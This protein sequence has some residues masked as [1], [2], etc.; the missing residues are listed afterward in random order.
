MRLLT[1]KEK[2]T[3]KV[4]IQC[5]ALGL[6]G[7]PIM[8][9]ANQMTSNRPPFWWCCVGMFLA[10]LVVEVLRPTYVYNKN[11]EIQN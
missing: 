4:W 6:I 1:L 11:Y 9:V 7:G 5:F 8:W 10:P 2:I 3:K